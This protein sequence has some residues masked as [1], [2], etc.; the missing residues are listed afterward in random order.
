MF[1]GQSDNTKRLYLSNL[2]RLNDGVEPTDTK[3][4]KKSKLILERIAA[5]PNRNTART[6]LIAVVSA[7]KKDPKLYAAYYPELVKLNAELKTNTGKSEK[8]VENWLPWSEVLAIQAAYVAPKKKQWTDLE[9]NSF[10]AH[11]ILS[12]YTLLPPRRCLDYTLMKWGMPDDTN[13]NY[14]DKGKFTFS[15]YKTK[16]TYK[17]VQVDVPPELQAILKT[18][19]K[20]S[21]GTVWMLADTVGEPLNSVKMGRILNKIFGKK[22]SVSMLRNIFLT[23]KFAPAAKELAEATAAMGTSSN[24]AM[25]QY[26]K[27]T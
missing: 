11:A 9:Y 1:G 15:N 18:L 16:G 8:Q 20:H 23:D 2:T 19:R 4:L 12:L 27:T 17:T 26:I 6:Y 5:M 14:F 21:F 7:V 24:T 10:L 13:F 3:F 22:V 25:N